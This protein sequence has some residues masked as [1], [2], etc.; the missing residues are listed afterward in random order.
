LE[1]A[2]ADV[3]DL[4]RARQLLEEPGLASKLSQVIGRPIEA[5]IKSL[6]PMIQGAILGATR[7][8][9]RVGLSAMVSTIDPDLRRPPTS[10]AFYRVAG[11]LSGAAGGFFGVAALPVEL[12]VTTLL[13]LRSIAEIARAQGEDLSDPEVQLACLEVLALGRDDTPDDDAVETGYY[14][15]RIGLA[16]SISSASQ[17]LASHGFAKKLA[18]PL[19]SLLSRIAARFSVRI[20]ESMVAKALPLVGAASGAALNALF[21]S[22][23]QGLAWAHFTMRRLERKY[24]PWLVQRRYEAL[25]AQTT[26]SALETQQG[27]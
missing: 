1:I 2:T 4:L 20:T 15:T 21:M 5:G 17:Y 26:L 10:T 24:G 7:Q 19:A 3:Y 6:P 12:P 22:H 23:F 11:G 8:A 16:Q 18:S 9:L 25:P 14:A 27:A 13:M